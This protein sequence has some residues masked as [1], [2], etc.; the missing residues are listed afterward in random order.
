MAFLERQQAA[1]M[2][3]DVGVGDIAIGGCRRRR[4]RQLAAEAA[5]QRAAGVM[6]GLPFR[7]ADPAIAVAGAPL[8][9]MKARSM[10][11][12]TNQ[13]APAESNCGFGPLR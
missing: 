5:E 12:P 13:C 1:E 2:E 11:S 10:P 6:F 3:D 7:R 4:I 9:E 8:L